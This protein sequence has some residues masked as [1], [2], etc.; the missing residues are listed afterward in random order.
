MWVYGTPIKGIVRSEDGGMT[1]TQADN[2]ISYDHH[3]YQVTGMAYDP[4]NDILYAGNQANDF[5]VYRSFDGGRIWEHMS[6][7]PYVIYPD[8]VLVEEDSNWVYTGGIQ[9]VLRSKD[10]GQTWTQLQP[11]LLDR[12]ELYHLASIPQSRT[13]YAAGRFGRIYKSYDLG[14]TWLSISDAVTDSANFSGGL[15][16]STL[17]TNYVFAA[18]YTNSS[19][20]TGG[21]FISQDGGKSWQLYHKGLPDYP[22]SYWGVGSLTQTSDSHEL[23]ISV[24]RPSRSIYKLSQALLTSIQEPTPY[25]KSSVYYFLQN[26]PNPFNAE[27]KI[28]FAFVKAQKAHLEVYNVF[29]ELICILATG[30]F[31]AGLHSVFWSGKNSKGDEISSGIYLLRLRTESEVL[32]RKILLIR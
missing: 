27:T 6:R 11:E 13:L 12:K 25:S 17:G 24:T 18:S 30:Q 10:L 15:L 20:E 9:G 29:G 19:F 1:A 21:I 4:K 32:I 14:G 26:Y 8:F 31:G 3:G 7:F 2:G 16:V 5:G 22:L 28:E 23:Y